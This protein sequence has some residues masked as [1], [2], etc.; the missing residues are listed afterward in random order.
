MTLLIACL[1]VYS[2]H[3]EP[4]LYAVAVLVWGLHVLGL[5]LVYDDA[6]DNAKQLLK[7]DELLSMKLDDLMD[8]QAG[9][10]EKIRELRLDLDLKK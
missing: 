3:M 10:Y 7:N 8:R 1:I 5:Y 4:W 6:R 2:F 9:L